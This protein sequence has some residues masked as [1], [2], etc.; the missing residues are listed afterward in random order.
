MNDYILLY[1]A[2]SIKTHLLPNFLQTIKLNNYVIDMKYILKRKFRDDF[3]IL[4]GNY[5]KYNKKIFK[6]INKK[7]L[8]IDGNEICFGLNNIKNSFKIIIMS[9][10][11]E[12][13][14]VCAFRNCNSLRHI[15][16]S[17]NLET[18]EMAAFENC[19]NIESLYLNNNLKLIDNRA[20]Y[21]CYSINIIKFGNKIKDILCDSFRNCK[22]L[23]EINFPKSV[24]CVFNN[25]FSHCEKINIIKI[26]SYI[27]FYEDPF[28]YCNNIKHIIIPYQM[29]NNIKKIFNK[30]NLTNTSF[31]FI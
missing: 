13:V 27:K 20:F 23:K 19:Y 2:I 15:Y 7:V 10:T 9:D 1:F 26:N 31:S 4:N 25:V 28:E 6:K 29:K 22:N 24:E 17:K 3:G 12:T 30:S 18:I 11:I 16:F 21:N 5:N 14:K 8:F